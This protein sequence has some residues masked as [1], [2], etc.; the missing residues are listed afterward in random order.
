MLPTSACTSPTHGKLCQSPG[1]CYHPGRH[2][3]RHSIT[4][5]PV[6]LRGCRG[7]HILFFKTEKRYKKE[8]NFRKLILKV[9]VA[10]LKLFISPYYCS[11]LRKCRYVIAEQHFFKKL[12]TAKN[13]DG[14]HADMKLWSL[15]LKKL[16]TA[17][18]IT[19]A[20]YVD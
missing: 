19:I 12:Q 3:P 5:W 18:K 6:R 10:V 17:E 7:R 2:S 8:E 11:R 15:F 13:S 1:V 14:R 4:G 20:R 16:R 9:S